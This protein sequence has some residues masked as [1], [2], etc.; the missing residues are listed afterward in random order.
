MLKCICLTQ[1]KQDN[2]EPLLQNQE[3]NQEMG[4][5]KNKFSIYNP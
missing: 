4:Q 3:K 2:I 5:I 1:K